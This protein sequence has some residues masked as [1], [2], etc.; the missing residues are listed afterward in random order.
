MTICGAI[1]FEIAFRFGIRGICLRYM[2]TR[3]DVE[4]AIRTIE[5]RFPVN[6]HVY[7]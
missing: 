2:Q 1:L 3:T 7:I 6:I 4:N 5:K